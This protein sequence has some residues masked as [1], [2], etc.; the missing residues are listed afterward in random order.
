MYHGIVGIFFK[1]YTGHYKTHK[2]KYY[3]MDVYKNILF[4]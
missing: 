3:F 1:N 4:T 2:I